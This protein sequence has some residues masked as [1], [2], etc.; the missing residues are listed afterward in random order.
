MGYVKIDVEGHEYE[1]LLGMKQLLLRD[2]PVIMIEIHDSC[3]TKHDTMV[4]LA[5]LGYAT[6]HK[7]TI[8]YS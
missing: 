3:A 2:R 1:A 4:F 7:L 8:T 5:Q 6:Y